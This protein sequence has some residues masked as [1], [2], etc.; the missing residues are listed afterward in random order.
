MLEEEGKARETYKAK[1]ELGNPELEKLMEGISKRKKLQFMQSM[2]QFRE[3]LARETEE[4]RKKKLVEQEEEERRHI[5]EQIMLSAMTHEQR[6]EYFRRK[7]EAKRLAEQKAD[8][9]RIRREYEVRKA[10]MALKQAAEE[11][12]RAKA[13]LKK[14]LLFLNSVRSEAEQ[15]D[16]TQAVSRAFVYSYFELMD[17]LAQNLEPEKEKNHQMNKESVIVDHTSHSAKSL[18]S[19]I[20]FRT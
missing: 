7:T 19:P 10:E 6:E 16:A 3:K 4:K 20:N 12:T 18:I 9:E 14:R 11:E 1:V 2:A 17:A 13:D 5:E 8:E 15:L